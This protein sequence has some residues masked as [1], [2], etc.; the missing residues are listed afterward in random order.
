MNK[1]N[2]FSFLYYI[3][4]I[5][6]FL[7]ILDFGSI[8]LK[9]IIKGYPLPHFWHASFELYPLSW[10]FAAFVITFAVLLKKPRKYKLNEN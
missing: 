3:Y 7:I 8:L 6:T 5:F 10:A 4:Y 9:P 2:K 1:K